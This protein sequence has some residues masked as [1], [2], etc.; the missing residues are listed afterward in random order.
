M[1][2]QEDKNKRKEKLGAKIRVMESAIQKENTWYTGISI[3]KYIKKNVFSLFTP[4]FN[5]SPINSGRWSAYCHYSQL[6]AFQNLLDKN[7]IG[8]GS[9]VVVHPLLPSDLVEELFQRQAEVIP[10]DIDKS[11]LALPKNS[12][13]QVIEQTKNNKPVELIIHYCFNGLYEEILEHIKTAQQAVIPSMLVCDTFYINLGLLDLFNELT[14]GS[15]LWIFGDSFWDDQLNTIL[16][17]D[18]DSQIWYISW[19]LEA[20]TSSLLEYHLSDSFE[21]IKP[22]TQAFYYLLLDKQAQ[23]NIFYK[24]KFLFLSNYYFKRTFDSQESA[25]NMIK[26]NYPKLFE[27]AVPDF[28]YELENYSPEKTRFFGSPEDLVYQTGELQNKAKKLYDYFIFKLNSAEQGSLEVPTYYLDRVY[29]K[30]FLYTN[31]AQKWIAEIQKILFFA[32]KLPPI[33][34]SFEQNQNLPIANFVSQYVVIIDVWSGV[35]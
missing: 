4:Q 27:S 16:D 31:D 30:Y 10:L 3:K 9:R 34:P 24:P 15:V 17:V 33:H 6:K 21:L 5:N 2:E 26:Q 35:K 12:I 25:I 1:N 20:R 19:H 18:L 7:K 29:I 8:F 28:V 23:E 22:L 13:A 11:T 32:E 14:L